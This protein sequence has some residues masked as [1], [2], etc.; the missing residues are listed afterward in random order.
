MC[1]HETKTNDSGA[2]FS[3]E[4]SKGVSECVTHLRERAK[5]FNR[6]DLAYTL[7]TA[8]ADDLEKKLPG[9]GHD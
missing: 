4:A 2:R 7:L 8:I 6:N 9:G 1:K 3:S 5:S